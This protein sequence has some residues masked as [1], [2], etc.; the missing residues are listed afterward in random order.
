MDGVVRLA[1]GALVAVALAGCVST[2]GPA[3]LT[4]EQGERILAELAAIRAD[5]A[6]LNEAGAQR[7]AAGRFATLPSAGG[8]ATLGRDDAPVTIVEFTDL[9]C[10][11]CARFAAQTL[12]EIRRE[13]VDSG[14]V[15]FVSRDLPLPM[16]REAVPAAVAAR[17]AAEQGRYWEY[18]EALFAAQVRLGEELY[19]RVATQLGLDAGRFAACRR[20]RGPAYEQEVRA[21]ASLAASAGINGTPTFLV[22]RTAP[23]VFS[24][25]KLSGARP[26]A[27]FEARVAALLAG[28]K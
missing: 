13:L 19:A 26:Y 16:H 22:G 15:R 7:P 20:E 18:R 4:R 24:G 12:P 5:L 9:Q 6:R 25:E 14:R 10:P 8:H 17:C 27:E 21:D 3:G 2:G 11:H 28:A 1:T 23:G